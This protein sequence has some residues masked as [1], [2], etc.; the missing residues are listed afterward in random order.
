MQQPARHEAASIIQE[1][2]MPFDV[3][4]SSWDCDEYEPAG[5]PSSEALRAMRVAA[6]VARQLYESGRELRFTVGPSA[7]RV[8]VLLCDVDGMVL[9][10][11]SPAHALEIAAGSPDVHDVR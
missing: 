10:H 4:P 1:T 8:E 7:A 11:M 2:R 5:V 6:R 9:S 3:P